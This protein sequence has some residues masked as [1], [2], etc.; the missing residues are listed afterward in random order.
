MQ[1]DERLLGDEDPVAQDLVLGQVERGVQD[2]GQRLAE[3]LVLGEDPVELVTVGLHRLG[4]DHVQAVE[5][6]LEVV[7]ERGRSDTDRLGDV[8]PLAVLVAVPAEL[9][10]RRGD[11]LGP[12]A[13]RG[14]HRCAAGGSSV[15]L[16]SRPSDP[17]S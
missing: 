15:W 2:G 11:D 12:L 17:S 6:G 13:A 9:L 16:V 14:R 4:L 10:R 3:V 1:A 8:G 5:L 7:V